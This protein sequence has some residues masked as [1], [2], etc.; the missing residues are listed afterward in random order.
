MFT[1][2]FWLTNWRA[3]REKKK[4]KTKEEEDE[5]KIFGISDFSSTNT[6]GSKSLI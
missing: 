2:D 5:K 3:M 1:K 6:R 4:G